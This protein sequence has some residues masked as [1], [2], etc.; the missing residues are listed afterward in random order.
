MSIDTD[1]VLD[2]EDIEFE[3]DD[4]LGDLDEVA[5]ESESYDDQTDAEELQKG[6]MRQADYTR[7]TQEAAQIRREAE[8]EKQ[9]A[10]ALQAALLQQQQRSSQPDDDLFVDP[11][12]RELTQVKQNQALIAREIQASRFQSQAD[13]LAYA[14]GIV[15]AEGQSPGD[16]LL[17]FAAENGALPLGI[18]AELLA[19]RQSRAAESGKRQAIRSAKR[20]LPPVE[21]GSTSRKGPAPTNAKSFDDAFDR[22]WAKTYGSK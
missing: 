10:L 17:Y 21:G 11:L 13:Q 15:A 8:F 9:K 14:N 22:A 18:A 3:A 7:K 16:A 19:A 5:E 20:G 2:D 1:L 12:E 6:Y 4:D